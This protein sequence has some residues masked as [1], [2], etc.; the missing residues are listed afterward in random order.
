MEENMVAILN[1]RYVLKE[2]LGE[3]GM[4]IVHVAYD[5]LQRQDVALKQ[6]ITP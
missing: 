3:G 6:V 1:D 2:K 5:R 4:G